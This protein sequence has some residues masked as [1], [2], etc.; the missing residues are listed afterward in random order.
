MVPE[1]GPNGV[2]EGL[3]IGLMPNEEQLQG[4]LGGDAFGREVRE[5]HE[6]LDE[7]KQLARLKPFLI[8]TTASIHLFEFATFHTFV[9]V[10][11]DLLDSVEE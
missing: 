2:V 9:H 7:I 1:D 8:A 10:F 6:E 11:I 5:E 4:V 3:A